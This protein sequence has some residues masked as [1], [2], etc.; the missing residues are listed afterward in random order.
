MVRSIINWCDKQIDKSVADSNQARGIARAAVSGGVE[1]LAD[2]A[3]FL[4]LLVLV[5]S[6]VAEIDKRLNK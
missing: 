5:G 6:F 1:G 4:G 2:C 3:F